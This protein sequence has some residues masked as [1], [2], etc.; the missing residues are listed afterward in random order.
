MTSVKS[1]Q[2]QLLAAVAMVLVAAI[3]MSSATYAWFVNNATV[4]ATGAQVK[5]ATAYSLLISNDNSNFGTTTAFDTEITSL[6]P[7][8]TAGTLETTARNQISDKDKTATDAFDLLFAASNEWDGNFVTSFT[9]VGKN[10]A[11]GD[12]TYYYTDT[13][14]LKPGQDGS[15]YL[16]SSSLGVAWK[17]WDTENHTISSETTYYS[18]A[19]FYGLED[20]TD[21]S[22]KAEDLKAYNDTLNQAQAL[23]ATLRVGF[24]VTYPDSSKNDAETWV[25]TYI[26]Q[27]VAGNLTGNV[28]TTAVSSTNVSAGANG[29][30]GAVSVAAAD[31]K[32]SVSTSNLKSATTIVKN[33]TADGIPVIS[34]ITGSQSAPAT[35]TANDV[36]IVP[37]ATAN[38]V[39][40]VDTYIWMEGCDVD[41]VAA[42]LSQFGSGSIDG[43]QFGF[44]L[45]TVSSST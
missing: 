9:E 38:T 20:A 10:T 32:I 23:L 7:V 11:F 45:G 40:T 13:I 12:G 6:F 27:L 37:S 34:G 25:G 28:N 14:Y 17:T 30:E 22:A 29:I 1:L 18:F 33:A 21:S 43:I 26:Y 2:K 41:T 44:C 35:A 3:A 8:S 31:H 15:I 36:A 4:T 42:T 16:D 24:V 39:Y 19:D 5:A